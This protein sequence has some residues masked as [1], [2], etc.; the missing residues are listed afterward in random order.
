VT[1]PVGLPP[2]RLDVAIRTSLPGFTLDVAWTAGDGVAVLFGPS[3]A[4]KTLTLQCLAGLMRPERGRIV[5]DGRV[6][7]DSATGVD[8]RPQERRVGYVF[9]GYALFPHLSVLDNVAFGLRDRPRAERLRRAGEV[10]ARLGLEGLERRRPHELSG[11]QRQRVALGRALAIDPALLLLDEPLSA[12]D[13]PTRESLRDE[14]R[15]ILTD[16]RTA[17]VVVT[18][19]FTEAYRLADRIV[20]YRDGRVIQAAPRAELLWRPASE[21]VARIMGMRNILHGTVLKATPDRIQLRWRGQL[22]EAVNSPSH[23]YLPPPGA[24]IAFF[25]RPEYVRLIRKDRGEPDPSH[26][27]NLMRGTLVSQAD[28][29]ATWTL[30][31]RLDEPGAPAQGEYDL[32]VEVP[33]LVH[34][35]LEIDRDRHWEF[36]I[37]RGSIHVLPA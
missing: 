37:H 13:R 5:V 2:E 11:G 1:V 19:D 25:I 15:A 3:G 34:E 10:I 33:R 23:A 21:A 18:H 30:A 24:P 14:L 20:V 17:A 27:M 16:W 4:G 6:F 31:L 22:L 29:G 36:S 12:L 35:I 9:Q 7:F 28:F 26:H 32:E 8:L